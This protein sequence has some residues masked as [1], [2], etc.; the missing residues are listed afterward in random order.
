MAGTPQTS[1]VIVSRANGIQARAIFRRR[2]RVLRP[3]DRRLEPGVDPSAINRVDC[4]FVVEAPDLSRASRVQHHDHTCRHARNGGD[5]IHE[6]EP[7]EV[8]PEELNG[9][10]RAPDDQKRHPDRQ[11]VSPAGHGPDQPERDQ[12]R[13]QGEDAAEVALSAS[14]SSPVTALKVR[15]GVPIPPQATGA[16]LAIR[17]SK[18]AW[19]GRNPSPTRKAAEMATGAPKPAAPSMKAP[20]EKATRTAWSRRSAESLATEAF[21]ISNWPVAYREVV[22]EDGRNDQPDNTKHREDHPHH[23]AC[24]RSCSRACQRRRRPPGTPRPEPGEGRPP[25]RLARPDASSP[26]R[27]RIGKAA[28]ESWMPA[29][30]PA[31]RTL[32]P[33][34][35]L[36][37]LHVAKQSAIEAC[38][39]GDR[40]IWWVELLH[41][42]R[43]L[44]I[45]RE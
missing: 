26:S 40:L 9:G 45:A 28:A 12:Q 21:M 38:C 3:R 7:N 35:G 10:E 18:A 39:V 42:T 33:H 22:E 27:T 30:F 32:H 16:V 11:G 43:R 13:K 15:R 6:L 20:N 19:K 36:S 1:T 8:R 29:S 17:H 4:R 24:Q 34:V 31:D 14:T 44:A 5:D 41:L 23:G 25:A 2:E 37:P